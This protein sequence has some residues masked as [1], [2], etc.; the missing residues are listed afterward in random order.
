MSKE[1]TRKAVEKL[2]DLTPEVEGYDIKVQ[3]AIWS[4]AEPQRLMSAMFN[5]SWAGVWLGYITRDIADPPGWQASY[6][7]FSG[8]FS[9]PSEACLWLREHGW[10]G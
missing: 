1:R 10:A 7:G 2:V 4:T 9:E 8:F 3:T 5:V 6:R